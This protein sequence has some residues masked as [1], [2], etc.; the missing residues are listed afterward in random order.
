M[1]GR[2]NLIPEAGAWADVGDILGNDILAQLLAIEPR[3]NVTPTQTVPIIVMGEEG[4]PVL[5]E[6][7]WGFIP[8]YWNKAFLPTMTTNVRSETAAT[9]PM[10]VRLS[11]ILPVAVSVPMIAM[12]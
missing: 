9:K 6:A 8:V 11:V 1:C 2:Y 5:I 10:T 3:Y 12:S 4:K 7:R